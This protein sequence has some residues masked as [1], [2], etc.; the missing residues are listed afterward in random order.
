MVNHDKTV[1]IAT[2]CNDCFFYCHKDNKCTLGRIEKFQQRGAKLK[3]VNP[4]VIEDKIC[5]ALRPNQWSSNQED[6]DVVLDSDIKRLKKELEVRYDAVITSEESDPA[7]LVAKTVANLKSLAIPPRSFV[8]VGTESKAVAD[9]YD[10]FKQML[11]NDFKYLSIHCVEDATVRERLLDVGVLR[12]KSVYYADIIA[13]EE[14]EYD[15]SLALNEFIN[16]E[17][18]GVIAVKE[19]R[20]LPFIANVSLHNA[21]G[22]NDAGYMSDKLDKL[23]EIQDKKHLIHTWGNIYESI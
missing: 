20:P 23:A 8:Y 2:H 22:G 4:V 9:I 21:L 12:C 13:G 1:E 17:L 6:L 19:A 5:N 18:Y 7:I 10:I 11:A 15:F 16:E 14:Y 3:S